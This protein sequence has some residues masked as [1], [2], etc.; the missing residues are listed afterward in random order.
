MRRVFIKF[1]N[2]MRKLIFLFLIILISCERQNDKGVNNF[3]GTWDMSE[4]NY[5]E[6]ADIILNQDGTIISGVIKYD[7]DTPIPLSGEVINDSIYF[8]F[9]RIFWGGLR[10]HQEYS[11]V[12]T[13]ESN[14]TYENSMRGTTI[15]NQPGAKE[16]TY[17]FVAY[18]R[19]R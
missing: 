6:N 14:D 1:L 16:R 7:I 2:E 4:H 11:G 12:L 18:K 17:S 8:E 5:L 9:D 19:R 15:H 3:T 13:Y 10:V